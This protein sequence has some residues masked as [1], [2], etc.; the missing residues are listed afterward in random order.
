ML[1]AIEIGYRIKQ[2]REEKGLTLEEL[3]KLIGIHKST[4]L[5]Y[6]QGKIERIKLPVIGSIASALNVNP[7]W[8]V[9]MSEN[10]QANKSRVLFEKDN[11]EEKNQECELLDLICKLTDQQRDLIIA[12]IKGILAANDTDK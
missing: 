2:T 10:K 3:A 7:S 6:E 11:M 9:G 5:R 1:S 12:Q 4:V 8:L